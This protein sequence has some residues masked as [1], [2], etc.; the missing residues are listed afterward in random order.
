MRRSADLAALFGWQPQNTTTLSWDTV[1]ERL[2]I[3]FPGDY[4][5]LTSTFGTGVFDS[6]VLV[7]APAQHESALEAFS[8]EMNDVLEIARNNEPLPYRLFPERG[9]LI[10][11]AEAG[12]ACS[13]F[14]RTDRGGPDDWT[15]VYC[16]AGFS[17][18]EEFAGSASEFL[19]ELF[20][21]RIG[22]D[23]LGFEPIE[24][25]EFEAQPGKRTE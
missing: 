4:K 21:G 3:N 2:G 6:F 7:L 5:D 25:P 14:W 19:C 20:S 10:P 11:W 16:D 18:W 15:I 12:D 24:N 8:R 1:E 22:S 17:E 13:V 9:G 23:L